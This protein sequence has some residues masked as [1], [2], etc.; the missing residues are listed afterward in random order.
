MKTKEF[1]RKYSAYLAAAILFVAASVIYCYPV[2]QGMTPW[3][4]DDENA[5][6]AAHEAYAY[7]QETGKVT[8]WSDSM[9]SGMPNY[10][11]NSKQYTADRLLA[12]VRAVLHKGHGNAI[13][14]LIIYFFCFYLLM[15][16]F[17]VDKWLAIAG[18]FALTLSSYFLTIVA[19]GHNTKTSTIALMSA[20]LA[21]FNFLLR[22]EY[23]AGIIITMVFS[24]AGLTIHPQ[25]SYYI[26]MLIGVLWIARLADAIREKKL[27]EFF[28]AT[29]IFAAAIGVGALANASS[30][31][32]NSEYVAETVR[33]GKSELEQNG[34]AG[35]K[36][37]RANTEFITNF[38]YGR[39]ESFSLL[40]PGVCGGA[41]SVELGKDSKL[42]KT[43]ISKGVSRQ[44]SNDFCSRVPMYWG[45]QDFTLGNVYVG[46]II[47]FLFI[48]GLLVVKSSLKWG[49]LVASLFSLAL[50]LGHNFMPITK[51][52][53]NYF[54][55]YDKF[56]A[57][58][59]ILIVAQ[60]CMPVLGMLAVQALTDGKVSKEKA[61]RSILIAGGATVA[62]CLFFA[63]AGPALFSFTSGSDAAVVGDQAWLQ[64][65][66]IDERKA[67]MVRD[68]FR[69]ILFILASAS[70]LLLFVRG[71]LKKT[72][73]IPALGILIV[74]DLWPV[75][76]RYFNARDFTK[77][78]NTMSGYEMTGYERAILKDK[79]LFRVLNTMGNPF[80]DSRTSL[81]LNSLGGYSAAKLRR[82]QDVIDEHLL[83]KHIPVISML[84]TK[85]LIVKGE[86]GKPAV[87]SNPYAMGN[88]WFVS[89]CLTVADPKA[90]C[91]AIGKMDLHRY[92]IIGK[93]FADK[94]ENP[95]CRLDPGRSI[96][97]TGHTP[98]SR[99]YAFHSQYPATVVFSE[100]YYPHGWKVT[101]DG[102]K[103]DHFRADYILRGM[104]VP[105][106]DH[107]IRFVFDPDSVRLGDG[108]AVAF[109]ILMYG[110]TL[111]IIA[112]AVIKRRKKA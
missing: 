12:P 14:I 95:V 100:I 60:I 37:E 74:L 110:A 13:W 30:V 71:K 99:E 40:I 22:K 83:K 15:L 41:T 112:L 42:Y 6:Y 65:A 109:I 93:D 79:S 107:V 89:E 43:L 33:G 18:A 59:S 55:L 92:A 11:I 50:A 2:L 90:E 28:V 81:Y 70:V 31:F 96:T 23:G 61:V 67:L 39:L 17:K 57:V 62:V 87:K 53:I 72:W 34:E 54:P 56:R 48:L 78:E 66:L 9:F 44:M 80:K 20:V 46:A 63:L 101:I 5:R 7:H 29:G 4:S 24:A 104:N 1:F 8:R 3:S 38:S 16:S 25:M 94:V 82:Y 58:S 69:S 84:N 73:L 111:A 103:A 51:L 105:A 68:S 64:K 49:L 32:A 88:A 75:D 91:E 77:P 36:A 108:I 86:D 97:L 19:A 76:K 85:Y 26:F 98:D 52:F 45:G 10:Q 27:R 21:G 102:V 47:C 35:N 106:G